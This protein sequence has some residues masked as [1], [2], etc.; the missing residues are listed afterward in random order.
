MQRTSDSS[1]AAR[2]IPAGTGVPG[3]EGTYLAKMRCRTAPFA[4]RWFVRIW[5]VRIWFVRIWISGTR[6]KL[7]AETDTLLLSFLFPLD[8]LQVQNEDRVEHWNQQQGNEG[9]LTI[10]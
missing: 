10:T 1:A 8:Q 7:R 5:F 2:P 6:V 4:G 9:W 3:L